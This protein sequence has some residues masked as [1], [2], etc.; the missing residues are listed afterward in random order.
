M[1]TRPPRVLVVWCPDWPVTAAG[2]A[3]GEPAAV[4]HANRVVAASPAARDENVRPGI[5]RREAQSR[6]PD[7][8]VVAHDPAR[9]ARAFE[10]VLQAVAT[11]TPQVE[12]TDPGVCTFG[13]RG[14]SRYHGGDEALARRAV[15]LAAEALGP[16]VAV[17][18]PP[19][20]GVADGRFAAALAARR[21]VGADPLVVAPGGSAEFLAPFPVATL[22]D[23]ELVDLLPRLGLRTLGAVA[24]LPVADVVAR[25]GPPGRLAHRR[26]SGQDDRPVDARPPPPDLSVQ[27]E[28]D[29]PVTDV[30]PAV[31][32]G[33]H[34]ADELHARVRARGLACTRLLVVAE[35]EHGERQERLWRH[36]HAFTAASLTERVRWQLEGWAGAGNSAPTGG[37]TLLRLVPDEVVPDAGR[38][39]GFWGGLTQADERA[40]R[41]AARLLGL[42]GPEAVTVPEW[43]GG[44]DPG[45]VVAAVPAAAVDL[46]ERAT[47]VAAPRDAGPWP[48][49][50]PTP[51][52]ATVLSTRVRADVV[53]ADGRIVTVTGR[54][55]PSAAPARLTIDGDRP[56]RVAAWAGPWPADERWWDPAH[57]RR[58][59]RFQ[60]L[61]DDGAAHLAVVEAGRWWLEA[62]YD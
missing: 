57:H 8:V 40:G 4:V 18:G 31:F 26:A 44:R 39:L 27:M 11:L 16:G 51:S 43:R 5:R 37:I 2:V 13:T 38:Q 29:P 22:G 24:A 9:D 59:A 47:A 6:C 33:K 21:A 48:G 55:W 20:V 25:F 46:A 15:T 17:A 53:D 62:V 41:A 45:A 32:A 60:L 19:G 54:G 50:L 1:S 34:L 30:G 10:P 42:L 61:T 23:P 52:P 28:L 49:R 58:R 35:T 7:L 56:R 3:P 36:E 12:L 14:P